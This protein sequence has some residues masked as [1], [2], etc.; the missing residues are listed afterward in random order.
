[1]VVAL[2]KTIGNTI[3]L[4]LFHTCLKI[5]SKTEKNRIKGKKNISTLVVIKVLFAHHFLSYYFA[6]SFY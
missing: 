5:Y 3:L 2:V 1:M 6:P 4:Y